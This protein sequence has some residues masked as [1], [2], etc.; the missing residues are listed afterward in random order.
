MKDSDLDRGSAL[1]SIRRDQR[2]LKRIHEKLVRSHQVIKRAENA[3]SGSTALL[4]QIDG[5]DSKA[6]SV[7]GLFRRIALERH[8][9]NFMPQWRSKAREIFSDPAENSR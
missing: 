5:E 9:Q 4:R 1:R 6:A 7:G 3:I 8:E 2:H